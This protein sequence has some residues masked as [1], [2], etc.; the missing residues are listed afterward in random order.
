MSS[1]LGNFPGK[2]AGDNA[3]AQRTKPLPPGTKQV[4]RVTEIP[5]A[6]WMT[7]FDG[8]LWMVDVAAFPFRIAPSA[9][10]GRI[11]NRGRAT[12]SSPEERRISIRSGGTDRYLWVQR[13]PPGAT[14][15]ETRQN[16]SDGVLMPP[17]PPIPI[18]ERKAAVPLV[19]HR[20]P[21]FEA[22]IERLLA[23]QEARGYPDVEPGRLIRY[24][25]FSWVTHECNCGTGNWRTHT[26]ACPAHQ[27]LP[28]IEIML[29]T[30][31]SPEDW[32]EMERKKGWEN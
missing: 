3:G 8:T 32:I 4:S 13:V 9:F 12:W 15:Y 20:L 24:P 25:Y 26:T 11:Y 7:L 17:I 10:R 5:D 27:S 30:N 23:D 28:L 19:V 6:W 14:S 2:E 18:E 16:L 29:K 1:S 21:T 22:V 31:M